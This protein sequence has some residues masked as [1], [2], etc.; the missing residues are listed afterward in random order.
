MAA[1]SEALLG[2]Q[3]AALGPQEAAALAARVFGVHGRASRLRGERDLNMRIVAADG[4]GFVLKLASPESDVG[5]LAAQ[6]RTL[7]HI[8]LVDPLLPVPRVL[9]ALDGCALPA[10]T[11]GGRNY[12]ARLLSFVPG[13]PLV[14]C[15]S[16]PALR[17]SVGILAARLDR[18]MA[19]LPALPDMPFVWDVKHADLLRPLLGH[20]SPPA[21]ALVEATLD[22][23]EAHTRPRLRRC[24]HQVIHNDLNASNLLVDDA[25]AATGVIDFGDQAFSPRAVELAVAIAHQVT[26]VADPL[27]AMEDVMA[28]YA[29]VFPLPGEEL[30]L[31][32][33]LLA[34]RLATRQAMAAWRAAVEPDA[35]Q[36][37]PVVTGKMLDVLRWLN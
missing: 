4:S 13:R 20:L 22:R 24:A 8:A 6:G 5:T 3:P 14:E 23:F 12:R 29:A 30:A 36:Y 1:C 32:P 19:G 37:D 9:T 31:V 18:A 35:Q 34:M 11:H 26:E 33:D 7:R 17:R 28:G 15:P 16:T 21:R 2:I 10:V 27:D 25:G